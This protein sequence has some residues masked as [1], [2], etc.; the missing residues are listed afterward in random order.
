MSSVPIGEL[1]E[2]V[3]GGGWGKES[4]SESAVPVAVIRGADFPDVMKRRVDGLPRR[5][6]DRDAA[7]KRLLRPGDLVLEISGGTRERPTGRSVFVTESMVRD[8]RGAL[9]PASFCRLVR[10]RS[11]EV[12]PAWL[13]YFLQNWWNDGGAWGYQNQSTGIANFRFKVFSNEL[14]VDRPSRNVQEGVGEIL[15]VLDDKIA[16]NEVLTSSLEALRRVVWVQAV[17]E[18]RQVSLS[19]LA[20]FVNGGAYTKDATETGRIVVR[21]AE[22]NSGIGA[23]TVYND[24]EVPDRHVARAGDLLMSWSGSLT[25]VRWYRDDAIVN[26]HIFKVIPRDDH[27]LWAIACAVD[28]KLDEFREIAAGKATT[29]GHIKRADLDSLVAWP[30]I[31][32][33]L[34]DA[35]TVLWERA[36][37]AEQENLRLAAT[38]DELLPLLMSGRITV[39]DAEKT[40]EEVV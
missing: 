31:S 13:F 38:R 32:D 27:P 18:S 17:R 30:E 3:I 24:L 11:A 12:D 23:S 6:E 2:Y 36:L 22:L 8:A 40:V 4:S 15:G 10:P 9:I 25:A 14:L 34:N 37:A 5:Y 35:G 1:F 19:S 39:K 28:T 20:Q 7:A 21:I 16:A 26:Q 33:R 29:M